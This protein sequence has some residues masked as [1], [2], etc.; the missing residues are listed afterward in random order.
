[1]SFLKEYF[2]SDKKRIFDLLYSFVLIPLLVVIVMFIAN[3]WL[4]D[5][6][7]KILSVRSIFFS[8]F[9][10]LLLNLLLLIFT[11]KT[12][13]S[14]L[15][16]VIIIYLLIMINNIKIKYMNEALYIS[17]FNFLQNYSNIATFT[18]T[19]LLK[20]I[21]NLFVQSIP[22]LLSFF[23][24]VFISLEFN[25]NFAR[26]K[27][28][29]ISLSSILL[30]FCLLFPFSFSKKIY[31]KYVYTDINRDS[32]EEYI[33]YPNLYEYYGIV[34][35]MHYQ[36]LNSMINYDEPVNYDRSK[37]QELEDK[38][39]K[40]DKSIGTPNII[41]I[42]SESF[43]DIKKIEDDISFDKDVTKNYIQFKNTGNLINLITPSFGSMT[44]NVSYELLTGGNM[45]YYHLGYIPFLELYK[46]NRKRNSLVKELK[47]NGYT[48]S[49]MLG[50]DS[51]NSENIMKNIGFTNFSIVDDKKHIKG[52]YVS[53]DYVGDLIIKDLEKNRSK[54]FIIVETMEAHLR[55][56]K[57]KFDKYDIN[58]SKSTLSEDYQ[59]IVLSYAQGIYDADKMLKKVYDYI[60]SIDEETIILF[61]G[62]HLPSLQDD[63]FNDVYDNL[64]YFNTND[65]LVN[66]YRK[67]NTEALVL[68]N[69]NLD[70]DFPEYLGYDLLLTYLV[71]HL[72]IDLSSYY[73]WL[74]STR[75][76]L[77]AYNRYVSVNSNGK[78]SYTNKL[79]GK[80]KKMFELRNK[81]IYKEFVEKH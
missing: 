28:F 31:F 17:D 56:T 7:L 16:V 59:D 6:N 78:I 72:D 60:N 10:V 23:V 45:T 27:S 9:I 69:Y 52:F 40:A 24:L 42:L 21:F 44:S 34:G 67:Y 35:G 65:N 66:T 73:R 63:G 47:N 11:K 43:F 4:I 25:I 37:L 74:Y 13:I 50:E 77:P 19:G 79:L 76:V 46:D 20:V 38:S 3:S 36:Y 70:I 29:F 71:N 62:D 58:V 1:M 26:R 80:E 68:S 81:M 12:W 64:K 22:I 32:L 39:M 61:F 51:Y 55:Y 49:I 53:D 48:T 8:F 30:L 75:D 57:N 14:T 18:G 2:F 5:S 54:N 33:S 41:V 15:I